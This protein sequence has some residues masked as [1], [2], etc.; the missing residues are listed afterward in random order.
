MTLTSKVR[1]CAEVR[2]APKRHLDNEAN[3]RYAQYKL[4]YCVFLGV[5]GVI[6]IHNKSANGVDILK[7]SF[8]GITV[9]PC[10]SSGPREIVLKI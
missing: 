5:T 8:R 7:V 6:I 3:I 2:D 10:A 4:L 9:I 1:G